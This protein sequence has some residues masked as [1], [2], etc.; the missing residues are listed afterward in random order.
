MKGPAEL[1]VPNATVLMDLRKLSRE[2]FQ[3]VLNRAAKRSSKAMRTRASVETRDLNLS[4]ARKKRTMNIGGVG[5][6]GNIAGVEIG[7][8]DKYQRRGKGSIVSYLFAKGEPVRLDEFGATWKPKPE[9]WVGR[10]AQFKKRVVTVA[11]KRG[12]KKPVSKKAFIPTKSPRFKDGVYAR[13]GPERHPFRVL[14]GL[15][16]TQMLQHRGKTESVKRR[17][18][19]VLEREF[20]H[21]TK[22]YLKKR[23]TRKKGLR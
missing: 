7:F 22:F 20:A 19:Q 17:G 11:V 5:H 1:L 10:P 13:R 8:S 21:S 14:Y 6:K 4:A 2:D 23:T 15:A 3:K 9:S 16:I 18:F 12:R